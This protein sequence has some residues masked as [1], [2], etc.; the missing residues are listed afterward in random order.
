MPDPDSKKKWLEEQEKIKSELSMLA[1]SL[2]GTGLSSPK[3]QSE[4]IQDTI[5]ED[6]QLKGDTGPPKAPEEIYVEKEFNLPEKKKDTPTPPPIEEKTSGPEQPTP[7][8]QPN[9]PDVVPKPEI[10]L[11]KGTVAPKNISTLKAKPAKVLQPSLPTSGS[12]QPAITAKFEPNINQAMIIQKQINEIISYVNKKIEKTPDYI[13]FIKAKE[14]R[15]KSLELMSAKNYSE[16]LKYARACEKEVKSTRLKYLRTKKAMKLAKTQIIA[17]K[18]E[19][20]DIE[21]PMKLFN[22]AEEALKNNEFENAI[23]RI[24]S[25]I[26]NLTDLTSD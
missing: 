21:V 14:F 13:D 9:A 7:V 11:V 12:A 15:N 19:G 3:A 18:K 25:C 23:S 8:K 5:L 6:A 2:K 16:S 4:Q 26:E 10:P 1:G 20:F 24:S 22:L 17:I